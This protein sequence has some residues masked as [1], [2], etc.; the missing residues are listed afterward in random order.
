[1]LKKSLLFLLAS[2][3]LLGMG[4]FLVSSTSDTVL[5]SGS[6][7]NIHSTGTYSSGGNAGIVSFD[8]TPLSYSWAQI[9]WLTASPL[10]YLTGVFW[11]QTVWWATFSDVWSGPVIVIPPGTGSN[12]RDPW[13]LSGYAWSENAGWIKLNHGESNASWVIFI[14]DTTTLVG[15]GWNDAIGWV[16]FDSGSISVGSGFIGKVNIWGNIWWGKSFNTLYTPW[17]TVSV[18]SLGTF[19]NAVRKNVSIISRNAEWNNKTNTNLTLNSLISF[20]GA[21]V[22][23][24]TSN[25]SWAFLRYSLIEWAFNNPTDKTR[26]LIV[27]WADIYVDTWV[28][29]PP[30]VNFPRT[31]I[32]LKNEA[33]QWGNIYIKWSVKKIEASLV[34]DR[35]IWSGEEFLT[36]TLSPYVVNKKSVFLDLPKNQLYVRGLLAS[37]NTIW[38]SSRDGGAICPTFTR[39]DESCTYDTA[40]PYDWNYFRAYDQTVANRAYINSSKDAFSVVME[41][42]GRVIQNPPPGLED[43]RQ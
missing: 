21:A 15:F 18:A 23:K 4:I 37:Y 11:I 35:T 9:V 6:F 28:V 7:G 39:N 20:N 5:L 43:A 38:W 22:Y 17:S 12:I 36:G 13:Y 33:W 40:I 34:S 1:M 41:V 8:D 26:S 16:P 10:V 24:I 2:V 31:L 19:L 3:S 25:P 32:A 30:Y 42:D 29:S 14:P 27:V